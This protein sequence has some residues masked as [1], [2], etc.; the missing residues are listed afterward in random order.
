MLTNL[1]IGLLFI[2]NLI[3]I[4]SCC[5]FGVLLYLYSCLLF[6]YFVFVNQIF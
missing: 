1:I 6:I 3:A 4:C 5:L 2:L